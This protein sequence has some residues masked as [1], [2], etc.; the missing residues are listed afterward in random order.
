MK[1]DCEV[2]LDLLPLYVDDV[3]G[4][5]SKKIVAEHLKSCEECRE[6]LKEIQTEHAVKREEKQ[7]YETHVKNYASRVKRKKKILIGSLIIIF[8]VGIVG[9]SAATYWI[10]HDPYDYLSADVANYADAEKYIK[11][12]KIPALLPKDAES[13]SFIYQL[14]QN[15]MNGKFHTSAT[16]VARMKREL[17]S[18]SVTDLVKAKE[19]VPG[20]YN[21][22]KKVL[23]KQPQGISYYQDGKYVYVF[24]TDGT[25][26]YF[27][28]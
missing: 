3:L 27:G 1:Y 24:V 2:V 6:L 26:Y 12:G 10:M 22:V 18:A 8:I 14:K 16:N 4:E 28:K 5:E 7:Q 23:E 19:V 21:D 15:K 13:I 17:S 25:V 11:E 20:I 9:A